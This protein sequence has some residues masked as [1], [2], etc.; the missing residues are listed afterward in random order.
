MRGNPAEA[1]AL[2]DVI[3]WRDGHIV[4]I[5][6][7]AL[8]HE[9]RLLH[10][11]T[12]DNL[13]DAIVRLAVR[14]APV[15]GV[16]GAFGVALAVRQAEREGWDA[17][18][19]GTEVKRIG[20]ARPTAVNLRREVVA[21]AAAIPR[22]PAAVEA[23][24]AAVRDTAISVSR[25]IGERGARYLS[26]ARGTRPLTIHTHCNTG[27]LACMGWGTALG[28]V[29]ALH[30]EGAL[31]HVIVDETR[32]LLQGARLT[33]WELS[34]LGIEHYLIC[35]G[36]GPFL[37]GRRMADAVVVG[38]DRVAANGDVANKIGTYA[39]AL[40]ARQAA[41]PFVVAVPESTIDDATES[42]EQIALEQRPEDEVTH[43]LGVPTA[44]AGTRAL[45]YAFDVTPA[46][47]VTA[48][49]TEDRLILPG[50]AARITPTGSG[51]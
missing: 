17:A 10:I 30:N 13:V 18:R 32:P 16:A 50:R 20:D 26:E 4:A 48:I 24:A 1:D 23:A 46:E 38:A 8:P 27:S 36:A 29:R 31:R 5:D 14:G 12:V 37:I 44:P 39:L 15:L 28:V 7:T 6:Q 49:V 35:D 25:R 9:V 47:L 11:T 40:A 22:G 45:N 34:R 41:I 21:T 43:I 3:A 42:G 33:C 51:Q 19:L 2:S